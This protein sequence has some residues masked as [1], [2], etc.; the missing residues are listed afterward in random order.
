MTFTIK[1]FGHI[2]GFRWSCGRDVHSYWEKHLLLIL[3]YL[4]GDM[5]SCRI[6][7]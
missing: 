1:S 6:Q 4:K 5:L 3:D 7:K 2:S